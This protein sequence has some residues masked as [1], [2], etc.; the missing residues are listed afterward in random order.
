MEKLKSWTLFAVV[1]IL[2]VI[3]QTTDVMPVFLKQ[4]NAPEWVGSV[5]RIFVAV[6]GALKLR[7]QEPPVKQTNNESAPMV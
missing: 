5:L 2:A 4:I 1:I 3:D 6:C 7:L